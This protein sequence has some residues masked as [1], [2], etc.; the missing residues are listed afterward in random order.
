[1]RL[2]AERDEDIKIVMRKYQEGVCTFHDNV[3]SQN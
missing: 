2:R 3:K 1:M